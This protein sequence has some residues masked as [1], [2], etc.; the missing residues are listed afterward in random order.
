M[1]TQGFADGGAKQNEFER[2]LTA[3]QKEKYTTWRGEYASLQDRAKELLAAGKLFEAWQCLLP[4]E[5]K[6]RNAAFDASE[7]CLQVALKIVSVR[8]RLLFLLLRDRLASRG[9]GFAGVLC[10]NRGRVAATA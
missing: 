8:P 3:E 1:E 2:K 7:L 6:S 9:M 10:A 5:K 4:V